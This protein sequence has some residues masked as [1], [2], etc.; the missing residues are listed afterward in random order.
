MTDTINRCILYYYSIMN[1]DN[2]NKFR[3]QRQEFIEFI[4]NA[5][6][7]ESYND[8]SDENN[9]NDSTEG[10][11]SMYHG[12]TPLDNDY[13]QEYGKNL[14]K[15]YEQCNTGKK[16]DSDQYCDNY[17]I[18]SRLRPHF[19][20]MYFEHEDKDKDY[21]VTTDN[22]VPFYESASDNVKNEYYRCLQLLQSL[23]FE[24][25]HIGK[26]LKNYSNRIVYGSGPVYQFYCRKNHYIFRADFYDD[27]DCVPGILLIRNVVDTKTNTVVP[28]YCDLYCQNTGTNRLKNL[29][30]LLECDSVKDFVGNR[31]KT[32][33]HLLDFLKSN[34]I[35]IANDYDERFKNIKDLINHDVGIIFNLNTRKGQCNLVYI[36]MFNKICDRIFICTPSI[37]EISEMHFSDFRRKY[38]YCDL[39]E[40]NLREKILELIWLHFDKLD[41]K[42]GYFENDIVHT[43]KLIMSFCDEMQKNVKKNATINYFNYSDYSNGLVIA[44]VTHMV[45]DNVSRNEDL[46]DACNRDTYLLMK[47][48]EKHKNIDWPNDEYRL[49]F[50]YRKDEPKC[51]LL[52]QGKYRL[53]SSVM[54][55]YYRK[56]VMVHDNNVF[57]P[58]E[59]TGSFTEMFESYKNFVK[60]F[61]DSSN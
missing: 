48:S 23:K 26:N 20:P 52:V 39:T 13:L 22:K 10:L 56:K 2:I 6:T 18:S 44:I 16:K 61:M 60:C 7:T 34:S 43:D 9:N 24:I 21:C 51:H 36:H 29:L 54:D 58:F 19:T 45:S 57:A 32:L 40:D 5:L 25:W 35:Q 55:A 49:T 37:N 33:L 28:I 14:D 38:M 46:Y 41:N 53:L 50:Y 12:N 1:C 31:Y 3:K 30:V 4:S 8:E 11:T 42:L 27:Q 47:M 17:E 15:E 59:L